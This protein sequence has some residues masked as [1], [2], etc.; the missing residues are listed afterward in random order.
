M[1][2]VHLVKAILETVS[3]QADAKGMAEV[4]RLRIRCNPLTS[5]SADHVRFSFD[6]VKKE[7]PKLA[8]AELEL[9]E[10]A[11]TLRCENCGNE[12]EGHE[13]REICPKCGSVAVR[14]V[15]DTDMILE[16]FE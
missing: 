4:K 15:N 8:S 2:E 3:G 16:Q 9:N 14:P 12:F 11:P 10:V 5:H 7:F 6:I 13:L 1:H